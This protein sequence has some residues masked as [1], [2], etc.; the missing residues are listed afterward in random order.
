MLDTVGAGTLLLLTDLQFLISM[1]HGA[2][3]IK[4][5]CYVFAA[6]DHCIR[7]LHCSAV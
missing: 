6:V 2:L 4:W 3:Y 5:S 1:E 7:G